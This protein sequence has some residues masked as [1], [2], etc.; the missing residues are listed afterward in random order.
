[1]APCAFPIPEDACSAI[2]LP[3]EMP[4][5]EPV[6]IPAA[7]NMPLWRRPDRENICRYMKMNVE[8]ISFNSKDLCMIEHIPEILETGI[9]SLKIEG[10][11]ED[12]AVCGNGGQNLQKSH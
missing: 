1:M 12:G 11:Y 5:R 2:I 9:D 6:P 4:I 3:E 10:Q 8:P 7:G